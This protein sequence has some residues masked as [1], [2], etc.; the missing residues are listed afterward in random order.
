MS[1]DRLDWTSLQLS[2]FLRVVAAP[3]DEASAHRIAVER[4]ALACHAEVAVLL[5]GGDLVAS[6]GFRRGREPLA[7]IRAAVRA[8]SGP[9]T[10]LGPSEAVVAEHGELTVLVA[11]VGEP[12][13]V[14]EHLLV[15]SMCQ[16]VDMA[17][18][19]LRR[20]EVERRLRR[21]LEAQMA[22]HAR[23]L[24]ELEGRKSFL[25]R[26]TG[27]Q[28]A[29]AERQPVDDV[30]GLAT[31]AVAATL[32]HEV[33]LL[34]LS[35]GQ[36]TEVH[37][38]VGLAA[39]HECRIEGQ[40]V[41]VW[42]A[43]MRD[44][45]VVA[46]EDY[47][48]HPDR[49]E[50]F[51]EAGIVSTMAA[52]VRRDG[53]L[54]GALVVASRDART[55]D[56][57]ARRGL[58]AVAE[59]LAIALNDA[60]ATAAMRRAYDDAVHRS[61]HDPLT[62][63]A[64]RRL[65][66]QRLADALEDGS[67]VAVMFVDVDR[68]KTV[69]DS[70]GHEVGDLVLRRVADQL[71]QRA[72]PHDTVARLSGDEFVVIAPLCASTT[73][74]DRADELSAAIREP[75]DVGGR[76]LVVTA[77]IGITVAEPGADPGSLMRDADV[78]MYRAKQRGSGHVQRFDRAMQVELRQHA[79]TE[80]AL[81]H[82]V[83]G[84]QLRLDFQ[85]IVRLRDGVTEA[86]EALVRWVRPGHGLVGPGSFLEVAETTGQMHEIGT[87]VLGAATRQLAELR[88]QPDLAHM[89]VNVNVAASQLVDPAFPSLVARTL[90]DVGLETAALRLELT[91]TVLMAEDEVVTRNLHELGAM[92]VA[93]AIDDFGTGYSSLLYLTRFPI[94]E[95]KVDRRFVAGL[96]RTT[97]DTEIVRAIVDLGRN[98]GLDLV[99][100]G[101]ESP[102]QL[103][104]LQQLGADRA[105]GFLLGRPGPVHHLVAR[106][107]TRPL[108]A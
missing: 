89:R 23:L 69:N 39:S 62:G 33:A 14:A 42:G 25:E 27:V 92:G 24:S 13:S 98:L 44:G 103:A 49:W 85:P 48:A 86:M 34:L 16:V 78:A 104:H 6:I 70:W 21:A 107:L 1:A 76:S 37:G 20:L 22:D 67:P 82:A 8:G 91:E 106:Q 38:A 64:N 71:V 79:E 108:S 74:H 80:Q 101:V 58:T 32:D 52:P 96:G 105:Q 59:Q 100:E 95:L 57:Q 65:A 12:F 35:D 84:G 93:L 19:P 55:Y 17:V 72:A 77:S 5:D 73:A 18:Q 46:A 51:V 87:W 29:I 2:N 10:L 11:R 102:S 88:R 56:D 90:D 41:G 40:P 7:A 53:E 81:R 97:E 63:L 60:A 47:P 4:I 54:A 31:Q 68:F 99:A 43:A 36:E 75:M 28:R 50:G 66:Q 61:H 45:V 94:D 9:S 83:S 3:E 15:Q 30:I 26:L